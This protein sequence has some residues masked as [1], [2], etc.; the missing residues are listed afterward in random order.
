MHFAHRDEMDI[1][2]EKVTKADQIEDKLGH[3]QDKLKEMTEL[4]KQYKVPTI[5]KGKAR[6]G[7]T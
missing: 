1:I 5:E 3:L 6:K 4:R 7:S 2:R